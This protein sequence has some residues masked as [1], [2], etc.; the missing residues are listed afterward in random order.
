M[1]PTFFLK[2]IPQPKVFED[3]ALRYPDLKPRSAETLLLFLRVAGDILDRIDARM[4]RRHMS[5][6]KFSVLMQLNLDLKARLSPSDLAGRIGVS[7]A[8]ITGLLDGLERAGLVRRERGLT[9]RR[10]Q[11]VHLTPKGRKFLDDMLPGHYRRTAG[12][13]A[14]LSERDRQNL[15]ALLRKLSAGI[16]E[17]EKD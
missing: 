5:Q 10:A 9:D 6:G 4:S 15:T 2:N 12:L 11:L 17:L 14:K 3:L 13:M 16:G 8:T 1:A 7:R